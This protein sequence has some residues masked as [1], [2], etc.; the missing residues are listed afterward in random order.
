MSSERVKHRL[1]SE[2][3][4]TG[5][6]VGNAGAATVFGTTRLRLAAHVHPTIACS[7]LSTLPTFAHD[8]G[9]SAGTTAIRSGA[10]CHR[11]CESWQS[12]WFDLLPFLMPYGRI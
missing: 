7:S 10:G 1:F 2:T 3:G 9:R 6:D 4:L 5:L 8:A 11:G 12:A